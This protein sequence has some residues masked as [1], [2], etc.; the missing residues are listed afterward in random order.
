MNDKPIDVDYTKDDRHNKHINGKPLYLSTSQ[1]SQILDE[2]DSTL[3]FWCTKFKNILHIETTGTHRKFKEEDIEK[4]K[5]IKNLLRNEK[6]SIAQVSQYCSETDT[7]IMER[8]IKEQDPMAL[9]AIASALAIEI[10][11]QLEEY[12]I[13]IKKEI[14]SEIKQEFNEQNELQNR[15][16]KETNK[17]IA[18][19][20]EN[21]IKDKFE[22]QLGDFK[23]VIDNMEQE[24]SRKLNERENLLKHNMEERKLAQQAIEPKKSIWE[25][26]LNKLRF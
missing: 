5:F 15:Q 11:S 16:H 13:L 9:T 4:L 17:F 1:V 21:E 12:K 24:V 23:S 19:T 22:T 3:R 2:T 25:I 6:Y 20:I 18:L 8:K 26:M 10:G 14:L 7:S